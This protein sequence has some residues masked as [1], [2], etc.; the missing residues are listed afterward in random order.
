MSAR[1]ITRPTRVALAVGI[2]SLAALAPGFVSPAWAGVPKVV[3]LE[4]FTN[5]L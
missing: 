4:E 5:V 1:T 3:V 2:I